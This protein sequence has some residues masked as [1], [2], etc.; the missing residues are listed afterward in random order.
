MDARKTPQELLDEERKRSFQALSKMD[1]LLERARQLTERVRQ[2]MSHLLQTD[3]P[4]RDGKKA[5]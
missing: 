2:R 4:A 3:E 1:M 5:T